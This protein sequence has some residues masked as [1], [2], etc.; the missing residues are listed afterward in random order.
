MESVDAIPSH[1]FGRRWVT[2]LIALFVVSRGVFIMQVEQPDRPFIQIMSPD[3]EWTDVMEWLE[4][5]PVDTHVLADPNHA[6]SYG[7][8]ER[9]LGKRDLFFEASKDTALAI[10]SRDV[11]LRVLERIEALG[12][13]ATLTPNKARKLAAAYDLDYLISERQ[14]M[15]PEVYANQQFK[16]Y[17]LQ[18]LPN[19]P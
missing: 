4:K 2:V 3:N 12:N 6:F 1:T 15:L 5:T 16:V 9:V 19:N 8:S 7:S 10:Y 14:M 13:F 17:A 18:P 11:A